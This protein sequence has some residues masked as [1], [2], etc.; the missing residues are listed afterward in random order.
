MTGRLVGIARRA[1]KR[2]PMEVLERALVSLEAGVEGDFRGKPG[3][4]QVTVLSAEAF[5]AAIADIDPA[6]DHAPWTL[7]RA[8]LLV[9]GVTLPRTAGAR[10]AIG[11]LVLEVTGETDPCQRMDEQLPGL[12]KALVPDWRGGVTCRVITPATV[13]LGDPVSA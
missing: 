9:E 7:R 8:N 4:R 1:A 5:A 6:P 2:A 12:T 11:A 10:I 3:K 13:A